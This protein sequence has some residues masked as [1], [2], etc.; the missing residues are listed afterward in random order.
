MPWTRRFVGFTQ[1][2]V[3][4]AADVLIELHPPGMPVTPFDSQRGSDR[5]AYPCGLATV[6][7]SRCVVG[8]PS[9]RLG[10]R[11]LEVL[12]DRAQDAVSRF[13]LI[14][15]EVASVESLPDVVGLRA[16]RRA[17]SIEVLWA[18][19]AAFR[20]VPGDVLRDAIPL[21]DGAGIHDALRAART[22]AEVH[23][24][25]ARHCVDARQAAR[26]VERLAPQSSAKRWAALAALEDAFTAQLAAAGLEDPD[27]PPTQPHPDSAGHAPNTGGPSG[28][29]HTT[30]VVVVHA[31]D[32]APAVYSALMHLD[33]P[34]THLIWADSNL[35]DR[36]DAVGRPVPSAWADEHIH[37]SDAA[38]HASDRPRDMAAPAVPIISDLADRYGPDDITVCL[39]DPALEVIVRE[40][41]T[42]ANVGAHSA[43]GRPLNRSRP[44]G[45]LTA[46]ASYFDS[47]DSETFA[48][49]IRH[50]DL[51]PLIGSAIR[52]GTSRAMAAMDRYRSDRLATALPDTRSHLAADDNRRGV[53]ASVQDAARVIE[54]AFGGLAGRR[55]PIGEWM[56]PIA[57][58]LT[59]VYDPVLESEQGDSSELAEALERLGALMREVTTAS[60]A[61]G[62]TVRASGADAL[63]TVAE[64]ASHVLQPE[65]VRRDSIELVDWFELAYD[66]AA[67]QIVCGMNDGCIPEPIQTEGLLPDALRSELGLP[68]SSTRYARD[69]LNLSGLAAST[70]HLHVIVGRQSTQGDVLRPSRLLFACDD[71]RLLTRSKTLFAAPNQSQ[72]PLPFQHGQTSAYALPY[73]AP[74]EQPID[75]LP[76]TA[77]R[78]YL[79][80]PY[81]FYL[82]HVLRL[83]SIA[84]DMV[85]LDA[86]LFGSLLHDA[87]RDF[88]RGP[89][90]TETD[91]SVVADALDAALTNAAEHRFG[92][93]LAPA[94]AIQVEQ[95]R[96][97]LRAFAPWQAARVQQGWLIVSDGAEIKAEGILNVD[98]MPFTVYGRIDRVER[99]A[100]TGAYA[101]LDYKSGE[102]VSPPERTHR[103]T[104]DGIPV[105]T[106]L[107][108]PLYAVIAPVPDNVRLTLGYINLGSDPGK[109]RLM[110]AA[111]TQEDLS[112]AIRC[113]EETVR[114][115]RQGI[116]WPPNPDA[117]PSNDG[118]GAICFEGCAE[119]RALLDRPPVKWSIPMDA[120][121]T[122]ADDAASEIRQ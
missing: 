51:D 115:I 78:D 7:M 56:E 48:A 72:L 89:A 100:E 104:R 54:R 67:V 34:V 30:R 58:S 101:V 91:P 52:G 121:H 33:L 116:F 10:R 103:Q 45:L 5:S 105:W 14:P 80:C 69:C 40:M 84:D 42:G 90:S 59:R 68:D 97:R 28:T 73:P 85:E 47:R 32:I 119:R 120:A 24:L 63:R 36:F 92:S 15:P 102:S 20:A 12:A 83:S 31:M 9:G 41:L 65:P 35:D 26:I 79:R 13:A 117:T 23:S 18:W 44:I 112:D 87:L 55:R 81:R 11:L 88:G 50:P 27:V 108:L 3:K 70:P 25:L 76:V 39:G 75:R 22:L 66:D 99:H 110:E 96:R 43:F 71:T 16:A 82:C 6:D 64:L 114:S 77:F 86:A 98:G 1:P 95:A 53:W 113:A 60:P 61:L 62:D 4:A 118:I 107:Q 8:V 109:R 106:D 38:I 21:P 17:S 46:V 93:D 37:I 19:L 2:I 29:A 122:N 57:S 94:L 49:L 74:P 111:W